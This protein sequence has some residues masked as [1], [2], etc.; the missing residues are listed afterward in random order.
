MERQEPILG[1]PVRHVAR[2]GREGGHARDVDDVAVVAL[3]HGRQELLDQVDRCKQVDLENLEYV[4]PGHLQDWRYDAS[5]GVVD[6][7]CWVAVVAPDGVR[8]GDDLRGYAEVGL[9]EAGVWTCGSR[10]SAV[11]CLTP[12][13]DTR[14][15]C[16]CY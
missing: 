10:V 7:D 11:V 12:G 9:V 2:L 14:C 6:E 8:D 3:H 16:S 5:A 13:S 1:A 15:H 4:W